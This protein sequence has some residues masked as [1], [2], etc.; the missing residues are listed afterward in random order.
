VVG[1]AALFGQ[2]LVLAVLEAVNPDLA[3]VCQVGEE[4]RAGRAGVA[5]LLMSSL[6]RGAILRRSSVSVLVVFQF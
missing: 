1:P 5:S 2:P 3:P 6:G 4:E